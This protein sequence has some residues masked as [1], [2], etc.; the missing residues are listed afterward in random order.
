MEVHEPY[1]F[2]PF[3]D[4][5]RVVSWSDSDRTPPSSSATGRAR[6]PTPT[7]AW[8]DRRERAAARARPLMLE[9]PDRERWLEAVGPELLEGAIADEL[10][11]IPSEEV[12][13]PFAIQGL[14]GTLAGPYD[15]GTSFVEPLPRPRRGG[16]ASGRLGLR[17]RR[18]GRGHAARCAPPPRRPGRR[19]TWTRRWSGCSAPTAAPPGVVLDGRRRG[20]GPGGG[21]GRRPAAHGGPRRRGGA[22]GLAAGGPGGQGHAAA[23]RPARLPRLARRGA[24]A[25]RDR[26]RLL[27]GRPARRR[28]RRPGRAAP[29]RAPWIEA[30]CQTV[31]GR[32]ARAARQARAVDVLPVL[33]ARRGRRGRRRRGDRPLRAR[34]ARSC[35]TGSSTGSPSGR[36]SSRPASASRG[37]HIFHGEMLPGPAVRAAARTGGAF[38][39]IEGLYLAGSGAHPG[40]AVTGAPGLSRGAGGDRGPGARPGWPRSSSHAGCR[41]DA[42]D[43]PRGGARGRGLAGAGAAVAGRAARRAAESRRPALACS[44]TA[45]DAELL[46]AAPRLRADLELRRGHRQHRPRGGHRPRHPGRPHARRAHRHAPPTWPLA[47]MLGDRPAAARRATRWSGAAS[48]APGSPDCLLGR[49][50]HGATVGIVGMGRIGQRGGTRGW[51]ASACACST[52]RAAAACRSSELLGELRLRDAALPAHRRDARADRRGRRSRA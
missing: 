48:G 2:A 21:L 32:L 18:H 14:I 9:P 50:L 28:R 3:P 26:H 39:G 41:A 34:P 37:G 42:L 47:L 44:P 11:G 12:R 10:A 1:L 36:A 8:A 5:R 43:S 15:P 31:G 30:A 13:V 46:D 45:V 35:R 40:G 4:G 23:R 16:R 27:A 24:L 20:G 33:P 17:P 38:G 29:P 22:A 49:D 25:G 7:C 52:R 19:C 51:R 6:T